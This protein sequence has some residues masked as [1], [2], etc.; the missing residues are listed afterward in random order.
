MILTNVSSRSNCLEKFAQSQTTSFHSPLTQTCHGSGAV[1]V[2]LR[3]SG[4][5]AL[6]CRPLSHSS[7]SLGRLKMLIKAVGKRNHKKCSVNGHLRPCYV[8]RLASDKARPIRTR[9]DGPK[10]KVP[11]ARFIFCQALDQRHVTLLPSRRSSQFAFSQSQS[12][13][14][15]LCLFPNLFISNLSTSHLVPC[16]TIG[17]GIGETILTCQ[18]RAVRRCCVRFLGDILHQWQ[19]YQGL[20]D[21]GRDGAIGEAGTKLLIFL[22]LVFGSPSHGMQIESN[23]RAV[24]RGSPPEAKPKRRPGDSL[25]DKPRRDITSPPPTDRPASGSVSAVALSEVAL[26]EVGAIGAPPALP[27]RCFAYRLCGIHTHSPYVIGGWGAGRA[28][29]GTRAL[30][31]VFRD[32]LFP[33]ST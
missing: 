19:R 22:G 1:S 30:Q 4:R 18:P 2:S 14:L 3:N 11:A 20:H 5:K 10:G 13:Q 21:F 26:S 15:T 7:P 8:I 24:T 31:S 23:I 25:L 28:N 29:K 33:I 12:Q 17:I 6:F 27:T 9:C 16:R 32:W